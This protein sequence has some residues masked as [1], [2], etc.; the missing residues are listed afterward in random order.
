MSDL[1]DSVDIQDLND[2]FNHDDSK[3]LEQETEESLLKEEEMEPNNETKVINY[4]FSFFST[5]F[6]LNNI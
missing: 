2:D 5:I 6:F 3:L 4:C 1:G